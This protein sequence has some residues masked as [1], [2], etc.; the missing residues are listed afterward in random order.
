MSATLLL[1]LR[2]ALTAAL[3]LFLG[4][5]LW[6]LW[7]D[8]RQHSANLQVNQAPALVLRLENEGELQT[9][10]FTTVEILIGRDPACE[11]CLDHKTISARHARLV[12]HHTQW[13]VEDLNSKNGTFLNA[14]PVSTPLVLSSGDRLQC[15]ACSLAVTIG[16]DNHS[17]VDED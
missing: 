3:Y 15:G 12:Y 11:C 6:I 4:W 7:Q 14:V 13:W 10:R 1:I 17:H 16:V 8:L 5:A 2:L 9:F